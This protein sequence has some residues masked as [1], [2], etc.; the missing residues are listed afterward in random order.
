M[1]VKLKDIGH[2]RINDRMD[3]QKALELMVE[4]SLD[5]VRHSDVI[6]YGAVME[7]N[8]MYVLHT[9]IFGRIGRDSGVFGHVVD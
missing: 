9:V 5:L 7:G 4:R 8:P 3:S 2:H 6:F 1:R